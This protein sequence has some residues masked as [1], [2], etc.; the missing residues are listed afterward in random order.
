MCAYLLVNV[1]GLKVVDVATLDPLGCLRCA[2]Q[3]CPLL[4]SEATKMSN[5]AMRLDFLSSLFVD[6]IASY[7][8]CGLYRLNHLSR[9]TGHWWTGI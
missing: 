2:L 9:N 8:L 1:H 5:A 4:A 6:L 3:H 7:L